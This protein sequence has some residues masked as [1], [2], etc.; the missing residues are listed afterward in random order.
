MAVMAYTIDHII[1]IFIVFVCLAVLAHFIE[2]KERK[3]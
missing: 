2:I 3:R 1:G